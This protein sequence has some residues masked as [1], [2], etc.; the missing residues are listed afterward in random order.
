VCVG[1]IVPVFAIFYGEMFDVSCIELRQYSK[2]SG[3]HTFSTGS[4]CQYG[5]LLQAGV[6]RGRTPVGA[7]FSLPTQ[8]P[9][10]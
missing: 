8:P 9:I 3:I 2:C 1:A 7:R 6:S 5:N 4:E 10:L